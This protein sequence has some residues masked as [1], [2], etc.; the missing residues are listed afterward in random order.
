MKP[1]ILVIS[2][3]FYPENFRINDICRE[4][5]K[6][7]YD[8]TVVTGI[9]NYPQGVFYE[10]YSWIKRR[11]EELEGIHIIR[12]PLISRGNNSVRLALNYIS[13]VISGLVWKL[14]TNITA[15]R[16]FI[17]EVSPM[18]QALVGVW[19]A[20]KR[21]IP[22]Y[23]YV[24][25]LWP[26][27][28]ETIAGIHNKIIIRAIDKMTDYIYDNCE[29]I[30]ATSLSF[31]KRLEE[32][33]SVYKQGA[34]KVVYCPQYAE[35]FYRPVKR[36]KLKELPDNNR[37]RIVFTGNIGYAQGLDILPKVAKILKSK[38]KNCEFI[39]IGNGRYQNEL[40][41]EIETNNVEDMFIKVKEKNPCEIPQFLAACDIAYLSFADNELFKMTI[42]AKLQSYMACGMPIL[43]VAEGETAQIVEKAKC[44]V[45]CRF[46]DIQGAADAVIRFME[47]KEDIESM[48]HNALDY[49]KKHFNKEELMKLVEREMEIE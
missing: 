27:N 34:S 17:F 8:I 30:F 16:V 23:I 32:R 20:R 19:F 22:C 28:V 42:P 44:G 29:K 13:F 33:K 21:K 7:G 47:G 6:W 5:V 35:T 43:A 12:I 26:E 4:W 49:C 24:Q 31:V 36:R 48:K 39:I 10:G 41:K 38:M 15:D 40:K 1:H 25:D 46:G 2:Q 18:T 3:Y 11:R 45:C 37:F 9:P 14:F